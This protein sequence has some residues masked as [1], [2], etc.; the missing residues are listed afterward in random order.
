MN[1]ALL[2]L[3]LAAAAADPAPIG[4]A[5]GFT[6][7][8]PL[9]HASAQ[10]LPADHGAPGLLD[11]FAAID[12]PLH[13]QP[14]WQVVDPLLPLAVLANS[15]P[16]YLVQTDESGEPL[17]IRVEAHPADG[18][19]RQ[20]RELADLLAVKYAPNAS[21]PWI[22]GVVEYTDGERR[23]TLRC[24][25]AM[26]VLEYVDR[27]AY[28]AW[29]ARWLASSLAWHAAEA[30]RQ[31]LAFADRVTLGDAKRLDGVLGVGLR[32]AFVGFDASL[33]DIE[34][35][36][37]VAPDLPLPVEVLSVT[38]DLEHVPYE[39]RASL[40]YPNDTAATNGIGE[41]RNALRE[42]YGAA[43]RDKPDHLIF[44]VG[45]DLLAIRLTDP[46]HIALTAVR[47]DGL[48]EQRLR[49]RDALAKREASTK[50]GWDS[51]LRG[52]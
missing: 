11:G 6:F 33:P 42:K 46:T 3:W 19:A 31:Q 44:N 29:Y 41:L 36:I 10:P 9:A 4:G 13:L 22:D 12:A 35:P 27:A 14:Q 25:A 7:G 40:A 26:L 39:V 18:C 50:V 1:G 51:T 8:N 24:D 38:L 47:Q 23:A 37:E 5:F 32:T 52:L 2:A 43:A 15:A 16:L 49:K 17:R 30:E 21:A 28:A 34:L 45:G 48:Q 20:Q